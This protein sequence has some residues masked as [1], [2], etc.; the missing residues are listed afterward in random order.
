MFNFHDLNMQTMVQFFQAHPHSTSFL[1]YF[2]CF[3]EAMAV[4]GAFIPGTIAM[5]AIGFLIGLSLIPAG[6]TFMWAIL[7]ALTGDILSYLIGVYFQDRIHRIWPF[8]RWPSLLERSEKFFYKHGGK[9]VFIGRFVGPMRAMI[10]MI[11]GMFKMSIVRFLFAAV[12]S[13][14]FWALS[15]MVPGAL[16]GALSLELPAKLIVKYALWGFLV[17]VALWG[18]VW[19]MQ[20]FFK[21]IWQ[22]TDYYIKNLWVYL[23]K[24]RRLSWLARFLSDPKDAAN[25]WQLMLIFIAV[26]FLAL[27][28]WVLLQVLHLGTLVTISHSLYYLVSSL[29]FTS[30]DHILVLVTFFGDLS[31]LVVASGMIGLW[32]LWKRQWYIAMHWL[33]VIGFSGVIV[34]GTKFLINSSRP[35]DIL[36]AIH[37]PSF[38]SAHAAMSLTLYGFLAVIIARELKA[39]KKWLPYFVAGLMASIVSFSRIY[40]GAHWLTD[41]LGGIF[42]GLMIVLV[43]TVSY[44][45]RHI[46]HLPIR[47]FVLFV[48]GAFA[49]TWLGYSAF[50]FERQVEKYTLIWPKQ[51]ITF[52][53]LAKGKEAKIPLYRLNRLGYPVEAFNVIYV[54]GL[55]EINHALLHQGWEPQPVRL[56]TLQGIIKSFSK[57]SVISHLTI[58]PQLYHNNKSVLLYIK[59]TKQYGRVLILRLW[60]ADIDLKGSTAP[61]WIGTVEYHYATPIA[62]SLRRAHKHYPFIG[63]TEF[64]AKELAAKGFSLWSKYY[65]PAKQP[66]EMRDLRWDGKLLILQSK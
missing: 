3:A 20:H 44:R 40:L 59:N 29:R 63:A 42:L 48:I 1:V 4:I 66:P 30:L 24:H 60:P 49:A 32:L 50:F 13:A 21:Q 5:P 61:L 25:H 26:L 31:L 46:V 34:A 8:T 12:T 14:I 19:L 43:A 37:D 57:N 6:A 10:P 11:A 47:E 64:L 39:S 33:G 17:F 53:E 23:Q 45:R 54:G 52:D 35:G 51:V 62:I 15:Y 22:M 16:L 36:Y 41:V 28:L 18:I 65:P 27:F 56:N 55:S 58:F 7:G 38:P 2:L 9:S